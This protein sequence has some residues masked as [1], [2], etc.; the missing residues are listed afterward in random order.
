M[1]PGPR[2]R[3]VDVVEG[4][5]VSKPSGPPAVRSSGHNDVVTCSWP[6][7]HREH[8]G[9]VERRQRHVFP[10]PVDVV[11]GELHRNCTRANRWTK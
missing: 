7:T 2:F 4:N 10:A 9:G 6:T 5:A 11:A 3:E 1:Q 8:A